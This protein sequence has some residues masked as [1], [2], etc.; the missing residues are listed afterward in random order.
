MT[1]PSYQRNRKMAF[2][3]CEELVLCFIEVTFSLVSHNIPEDTV[4][5]QTVCLWAVLTLHSG[6]VL[7]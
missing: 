7:S 5:G 4:W 1:V 2:R 6:I 3:S